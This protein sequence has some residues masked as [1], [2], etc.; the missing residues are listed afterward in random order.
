[1]N[2][3]ASLAVE[4][5]PRVRVNAVTAG[6]ILTEQAALHY[7]GEGG[8]AA[9]AA[10]IPAGRLG[11]PEDVAQACLWL[12]SDAAGWVSGSSLLVHGGGEMPAYLAAADED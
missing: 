11:L 3:T 7:G 1:L 6:P 4:W 8:Q 10:T 9:V 2:L 12:C 5:A